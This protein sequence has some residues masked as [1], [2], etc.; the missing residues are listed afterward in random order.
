[1]GR[2][3]KA[4]GKGKKMVRGWAESDGKNSFSNKI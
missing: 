2:G 4:G 1:V 3:K